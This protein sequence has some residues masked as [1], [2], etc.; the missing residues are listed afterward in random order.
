LTHRDASAS[1][2]AAHVIAI[3]GT[4]GSVALEK[5]ACKYAF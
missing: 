3:F 5:A 4:N 1:T 2:V